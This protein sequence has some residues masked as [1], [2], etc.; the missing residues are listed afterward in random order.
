M[1]VVAETVK[2]VK[3]ASLKK[4]SPS[5]AEIELLDVEKALV[6]EAIEKAGYTVEKK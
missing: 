4:I 5:Q 1:M 2:T 6:I 3:G